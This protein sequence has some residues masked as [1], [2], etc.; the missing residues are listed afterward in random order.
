V[1]DVSDDDEGWAELDEDHEHPGGRP[2]V[3]LEVPDPPKDPADAE[4]LLT[5][6]AV[7]IVG[8]MP[9]STN[10]TFLVE[11]RDEGGPDGAERRALAVYKP[12]RGERPLWDFPGGLWRREVAAHRLSAWLGWNLVPCTV[13][14]GDDAPLGVGSLQQFVPFDAEAHYFTLIEDESTH[15]V[16]RRLCVFDLLANNTD[17][18]GGHVL[19]APDGGI[20]AIDNGLSFHVEPKLR[21]V[22][23]EFGGHPMAAELVED[24]ERLAA[25]GVPDLVAE[26]LE[27]D[28][29]E[30]LLRR[31]RAVATNRRFPIDRSGRRYPWPLV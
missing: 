9:W 17:R 11:V 15:D 3:R 27:P 16:L 28:E 10:A 8:R 2:V 13:V 19:L 21:T 12:E 14:R 26:L 23:W 25:G 6:G 22:I 20:W 29:Q 30:A 1:A 5:M 24:V 7:T 31:A 4:A 18:K